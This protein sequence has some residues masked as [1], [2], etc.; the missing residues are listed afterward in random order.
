MLQ[1]T[2]AGNVGND[3]E[4][5]YTANGDPILRFNIASNYTERNKDG[6]YE[7]RVEWVR[8]TITGKRAESLGQY[9]RKGTRVTV[10][11]Q[12]KAR[13]WVGNNDNVLHA[14]LEM[15]AGEID[16]VNQDGNGQQ[17]RPSGQPA[18]PRQTAA[19]GASG[20]ADLPF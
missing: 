20:N 12:L 19:N 5:K 13:P 10:V 6:E 2:L 7:K 17:D 1:A 15:L 9:I 4:Q 14:G 3:A 16:F 8:V 11:G 18:R